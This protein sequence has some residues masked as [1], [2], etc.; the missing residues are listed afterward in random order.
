[1]RSIKFRGR[2]VRTD[3]YVYGD[4]VH[5]GP[6]ENKPGIIDGEDFYHEVDPDTVAQLVGYDANGNEVYEGD[7]LTD[8]RADIYGDK[9]T[10]ILQPYIRH[11]KICSQAEFIDR[12]WS[13]PLIEDWEVKLKENG[14]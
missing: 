13:K 4:F 8:N 12:F 9:V 11:E 6:L 7:E 5:H 10:A 1:M 2:D 3:E 14:Q